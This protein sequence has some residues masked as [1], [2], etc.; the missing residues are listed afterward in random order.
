MAID[1]LNKD[2]VPEPIEGYTWK[3]GK[4]GWRKSK[5]LNEEQKT[6]QN[7]RMKKLREI[8][9]AKPKV[10]KVPKEKV[11]KIKVAKTTAPVAVDVI[12]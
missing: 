9:L 11:P 4:S 6:A 1:K 3:F 2:I 8:R 12:P 10:E 5:V 7:D